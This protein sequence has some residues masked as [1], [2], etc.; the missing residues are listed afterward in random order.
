M[1]KQPTE[2][3]TSRPSALSF[4]SLPLDPL[5][6]WGIRLEPAEDAIRAMAAFTESLAKEEFE[7]GAAFGVDE[8]EA[9]F[10]A[11]IDAQA[12][13][14]ALTREDHAD[15]A[16]WGKVLGPKRWL[17][18]QRIRIDRLKAWW[19]ENGGVDI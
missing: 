18:A 10:L 2:K 19:A 3:N 1:S 6:A 5:Y 8:L 17:E 4:G 14:G 12:E 9:R 13:S 7:R 15:D 16:M 11:W